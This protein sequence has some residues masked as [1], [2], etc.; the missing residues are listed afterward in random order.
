MALKDLLDGL[1]SS[2]RKRVS[3]DPV[4]PAKPLEISESPDQA[5]PS[6]EPIQTTMSDISPNP[7]TVGIKE[8]T[9]AAVGAKMLARAVRQAFA[10]DKLSF[11]DLGYFLA[12]QSSVIQA[13][14]GAPNI[15]EEA[16]DL[17]RDEAV[18]LAGFLY[19]FLFEFVGLVKVLKSRGGEQSEG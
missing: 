15:Q 14:E 8:T 12:A 10:D 11:E 18:Q 3:G 16:L 19:D 4:M 9:E 5:K 7:S 17:Q 2:R 13:I 1:F 6:L